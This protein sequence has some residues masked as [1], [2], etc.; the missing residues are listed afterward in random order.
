MMAIAFV[1]KEGAA[2]ASYTWIGA[3]V[4][5]MSV[6]VFVSWILYAL[7]SRKESM[8]H[9]A[10]LPFDLDDPDGGVS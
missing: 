2:A 7:L 5:V 8:E 3:V 4:T 10:N 6:V 1:L 9:A